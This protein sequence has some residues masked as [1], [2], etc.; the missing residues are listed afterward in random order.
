[1]GQGF[2]FKIGRCFRQSLAK[3]ICLMLA[4]VF[5]SSCSLFVPESANRSDAMSDRFASPISEA[6]ENYLTTIKP[7]LDARCVSC[8]A[9]YDAP[10]QL[11]LSSAEGVDRGLHTKP[12]Y[13]ATRL[14]AA[15]PSRLFIDENSRGDWRDEGFHGVLYEGPQ[16]AE[17]NKVQSILYQSLLLKQNNPLPQN[18]VLSEDE[19]D[20][21][22]N[23]KNSCP[24]D[25]KD[26]HRFAK[27]NP[28]AGM[29][30]GLPGLTDA[31]MEQVQS[32]I[33]AGAPMAEP[34]QLSEDV[35]QQ[36]SAWEAFLNQDSNK[37][38]LAARYIYEHLYLG[39]I[40]FSNA[41]LRQ[42]D[43][44]DP[45]EKTYFKLVRSKTPPGQP[46]SIIATR[47]PS[48][49][50]GVD[51]VYYRLQR[52]HATIVSK[53]H[54]PYPLNQQR[55]DWMNELFFAPDYPVANLP[56]YNNEFVNPFVTFAAIP[57]RSRYRF[58]LEE[59]EFIIGG[60]IKGPVCRGQV[61]VD[62]INDHFWVFFV[63]PDTQAIPMIDE[64]VAT[65]SRNLRLPGEEGSN[66]GILIPWKRYSE[67]NR[68]WLLAKRE[69]LNGI[70]K[71]KNTLNQN[72]VW[73]GDGNNPN[74]ALT[75]F[76]HFDSASVVKGLVGQEPK[77]VWI[78]DYPLLERIHYLLTVDFDVY[79]NI[80]HQLNTRL[81]M[82]FLRIEGEYNFLTLMPHKDR[83]ELRDFWYRNASDRV[84][85]HLYS[86][87]S[88]LEESPAINYS[89]V[90]PKTELLSLLKKRLGPA[91]A[92][93]FNLATAAIPEK[94]RDALLRLQSL[95]GSASTLLPE[96][97]NLLV[98][99]DSGEARVYS[100]LANRA[101]SNITSLF[102]EEKYRLPE[103]DT[104]TVATGVV[105]DNPNAF[106][107]AREQ[108]LSALVSQI[109]RLVTEADYQ[110]LKDDFG[111]RRTN[112]NFWQHSDRVHQVF[113]RQLPDVAARLD[114]NRLENR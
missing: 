32:W 108:D 43:T 19:F 49:D 101:H 16:D 56:G 14:L 71:G 73:D 59:S 22:L 113:D 110:Q 90:N 54:L 83:F 88:Y 95:Q 48:D 28:L 75:I 107:S 103:E 68:D 61:A 94:Q 12:V 58:M 105:G 50:P 24:T 57:A 41:D 30:Y 20:F 39:N 38:R 70:F 7:L 44:Q 77:T 84:K 17:T 82:D 99:S 26:Y 74:A 109:E 65:Q 86:C 96:V 35:R 8:H 9:C 37:G 5:L 4:T 36:I 98:S 66:T 53:T 102:K 87:E 114:Y 15:Q 76:R 23:R 100:I 111:I 46:L 40:Y 34:T 25:V 63:D 67:A 21:A 93:R 92:P 13:S 91:M 112:P 69:A 106:L 80:G 11:K 29:P 18:K 81:Y 104:I 72:L 62:V 78:I 10:C 42:I 55:L 45:A 51:R 97:T 33:E 3:S 1:M 89:S 52:N 85:E 64:F 47:R 6:G 60:F 79:G 31:E 2:S 27:K